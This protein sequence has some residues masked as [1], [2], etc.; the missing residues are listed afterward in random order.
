MAEGP[1]ECGVQVFCRIRPLNKTE[2]KNG[3][4]FLPKFPSE[5][6][7]SIGLNEKSSL[8]SPPHKKLGLCGVAVSSFVLETQMLLD[9]SSKPEETFLMEEKF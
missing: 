1:A 6:T 8:T 7:I 9:Y 5:D 4:R 2:E 3:D